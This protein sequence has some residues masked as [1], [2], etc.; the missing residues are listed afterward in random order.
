MLRA[1]TSGRCPRA[2]RDECGLLAIWTECC[3]AL[4]AIRRD[5]RRCARK[6]SRTRSLVAVTADV[7]PTPL[8]YARLEPI[9]KVYPFVLFI[10]FTHLTGR[11]L[12]AR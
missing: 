9:L 11:A 10:R 4:A 2:R 8:P 12:R 5:F 7:L 6:W 3:G 1:L